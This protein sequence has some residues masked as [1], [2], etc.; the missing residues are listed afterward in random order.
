MLKKSLQIAGA[1][2]LSLSLVVGCSSNNPNAGGE[3]GGEG[4]SGKIK[5]DGSST[6]YP[7]TSAVAEEFMKKNPGVDV[8]VS[9]S[10]TGGGFE[11]WAKKETD[12]SDASRPIKD[13]EKEAAE[14]AGLEPIEVEVAKDGITVVV[15]KENDFVDK[16]TVDQLKKIW[17]PNSKVK[18]WKDVNPEWPD[19]PIKLYGPGTSS[20]T[21][22]YFTEEIVGEEGKSRTDYTQS[23]DDNT[24]VQGVAGDK[25]ALGYFGYAY[26]EEN[27]DKLKAVPI[28]AGKGA[29][30]PTEETIQSGKYA[31]LS[32][33]IFVYASKQAMEKEHIKKFMEFYLT[34][35][36]ELVPEVGYIKLKD[37]KYEE[38]LKELGIK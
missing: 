31:P 28:D 7:V 6:V 17:E 8:T 16:L 3:G 30:E 37:E 29:V 12:L 11:K 9:Q 36:K 26:Y 10:G 13:E 27:K 25:N 23:E 18:T 20:G 2:V 24:L 35:G 19:K 5:I 32:R 33:P 38:E 21:F 15:N 34:E 22:D 1:L 14:K 4:L